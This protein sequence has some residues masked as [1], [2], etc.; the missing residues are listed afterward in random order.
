MKLTSEEARFL[1]ALLREQNQSGCRGPAHDL[2]RSNAYPNAPL[3]GPGAIAF[4]YETVPLTSLLLRE[5]TDL[6]QIDDF[7]HKVEPVAGLGWPWPS[8]TEYQARL[9]LARREWTGGST[10]TGPARNGT[11]MK[12]VPVRVSR[13][14]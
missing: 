9:E 3:I 4:S 11:E 8:A 13:N 2:L 5:F 12:S 1:T 7:L 6:Q 10:Q 14:A